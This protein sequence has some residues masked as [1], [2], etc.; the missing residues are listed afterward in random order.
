[1]T[2]SGPPR[3]RSYMG[4]ARV[5]ADGTVTDVRPPQRGPSV[6]CDL[7]A[8]VRTLAALRWDVDPDRPR[9]SYSHADVVPGPAG[10][11]AVITRDL[12]DGATYYAILIPETDAER[13][14]VDHARRLIGV[15]R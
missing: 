2:Y 4:I 9:R 8:V 12:W 15:P 5:E 7:Q 10:H 6:V 14:A 13:V 3:R 11:G 1:M